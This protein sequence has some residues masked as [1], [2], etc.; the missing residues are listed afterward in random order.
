MKSALRGLLCGAALLATSMFGSGGVNAQTVT[1]TG[2]A[3]LT[4]VTNAGNITIN[5]SATKSQGAPSC[6]S[7][8]VTTNQSAITLTA[9]CFQGTNPITSYTFT[10]PGVNTTQA[11]SSLT[12]AAPTTSAT[13]SVTASDGSSSSNSVSGSYTVGGVP[14]A[15]VPVDLSACTAQGFTG[16]L[17][18]LS[19]APGNTRLSSDTIGSFGN[20]NALVLR[21]T[22]PAV[23]GDT[24]S[25]QFSQIAGTP[26]V[27]RVATLA[28]QPCQIATSASSSGSILASAVS[29]S[30]VFRLQIGGLSRLGVTALTPGTT[31]YITVVNRNSY[32]D[33][34]GS[35]TKTSSCGVYTDLLN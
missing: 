24:S 30:P 4:S 7:L 23:T 26:Q 27:F 34:V 33:T 1:I 2:C 16:K 3:S 22:T 8:T 18:D 6:T 20:A 11:G 14:P 32:S 15:T 31:Y 19:Y 9:N 12:I 25:I 28:T 10:G 5:C 13:Y 29:Q 35:C 21:F 17:L